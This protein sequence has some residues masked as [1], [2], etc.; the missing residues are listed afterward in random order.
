MLER[1]R[2]DGSRTGWIGDDEILST[3]RTD[4]IVHTPQLQCSLE[5]S[6]SQK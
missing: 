3:M 5:K 2:V 4:E 1:P 6:I